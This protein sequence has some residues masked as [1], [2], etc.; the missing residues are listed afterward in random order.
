MVTY[1]FTVEV[2]DKMSVAL[3]KIGSVGKN[4]FGQ[5]K[6]GLESFERKISSTN[7]NI[8]GLNAHLDK[9]TET[10]NISI[11]AR[12]IGVLNRQIAATERQLER[13]QN[14]GKN[15]VSMGRI[16]ASIG[17]GLG[18]AG[19]AAASFAIDAAKT[20]AGYETQQAVLANKLGSKQKAGANLQQVGDFA[21]KFGLN[22]VEARESFVKLSNGGMS[23]T[24]KKMEN[25]GNIVARTG[26]KNMDQFAEGILDAM[27]GEFVRLQE[28]GIRGKQNVK[29][30]TVTLKDT[31]SGYT[32]TV[33]TEADAIMKY[34]D[35]VSQQEGTK[36]MLAAKAETTEAGFNRMEN[37]YNKVKVSFATGLQPMTSQVSKSFVNLANIASQYAAPAARTLANGLTKVVDV[38]VSVISYVGQNI[39]MFTEMGYVV[40]VAATLYA[41][42]NGYVAIANIRNAYLA[43]SSASAALGNGAL[44]VSQWALNTA[45]SA[46]PIGAV[47][48]VLALLGA[49]VVYAWNKFEWFRGGITGFGD[50][51]MVVFRGIGE[52]VG[53]VFHGIAETIEGMWNLD[54]TKVKHG[55]TRLTEGLLTASPIG[56][57]MKY[58]SQMADAA[59]S[60]YQ[61]GALEISSANATDV[62]PVAKPFSLMRPDAQP[63]LSTY[64]TKSWKPKTGFSLLSPQYDPN[65]ANSGATAITAGKETN[66][67]GTSIIDKGSDSGGP[68]NS[69][70]GDRVGVKNVYISIESLV[71]EINN[72]VSGNIDDFERK[73]GAA[74]TKVIVQASNDFNV[75][76]G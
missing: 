67:G 58:G 70:K 17:V 66:G 16:G 32:R 30:G 75:M 6:T 51:M 46:N 50:T 65:L 62:K 10:R 23:P 20:G 59:M 12:E 39:T 14:L 3:N 72:H 7:N 43:A 56:F 54:W 15:G 40:G 24:M 35:E 74:V 22:E 52:T 34:L 64:F 48:T 38:S 42:Y 76:G 25:W 19:A 45:M 73:V 28:F 31:V 18:I 49:G 9:L 4:A 44:T 53:N 41:A 2:K 69:D 36:G 26:G 71:K 33:K 29:D 60:G 27:G 5:L 68:G 11:N 37:A 55:A 8:N 63:E 47:I 57:A 1:G 61:R 21:N 13:M